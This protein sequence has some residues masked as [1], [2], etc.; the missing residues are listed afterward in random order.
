MRFLLLLGVLLLAQ[1]DPAYEA[2]NLE[3]NQKWIASRRAKGESAQATIGVMAAG[4]FWNHSAVV[5]T[6]CLETSGYKVRALD[7]GSSLQGLQVVVLPGGLAPVQYQ[8]LGT[9]GVRRLRDFTENGGRC[10]A[11]CAGAY[12]VSSTVRYD[13]VDYPYPLGFFDGVAE[14]PVAG[15]ARYPEAGPVRLTVTAEGEAEGLGMAQGRSYLYG[16]GP[17]FLGGTGATVLMRYPDGTAACIRRAFG[18]GEVVAL[19]VHVELS[20][21]GHLEPSPEESAGLLK[22]L[23]APARA[24]E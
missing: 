18:K 8:G 23:I 20:P 13:G 6:T 12:L 24:G 15:L 19:G 1:L 21:R 3:A 17:R 5:L 7:A 2:R 11:I 10:L 4:G 16:G 14:G 22:V 9:E